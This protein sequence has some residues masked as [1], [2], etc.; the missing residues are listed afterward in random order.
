[1]NEKS[2][3]IK[4]NGVTLKLQSWNNCYHA[5]LIQYIYITKPRRERVT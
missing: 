1:M 4:L 5:E 3:K 2:C